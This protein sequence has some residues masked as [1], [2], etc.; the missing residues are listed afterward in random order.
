MAPKNGKMCDS[1]NVEL[2]GR[3]D[4]NEESFKNRFNIYL[5]NVKSVLDYYDE[6]E[7][8]YVVKSCEH[9]E[10]TF[11]IVDKILKEQD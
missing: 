6:K 3:S 2:S 9:K 4:D 7:V 10:D 5:N 11:E 8:L 1:C